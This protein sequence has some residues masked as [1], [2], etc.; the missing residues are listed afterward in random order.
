MV[1]LRKSIALLLL[2]LM[3]TLCEQAWGQ[4][5]RSGNV[6][7]TSKISTQQVYVGQPFL[8]TV[9]V[10]T[11]TWFASPVLLSE[12]RPRNSAVFRLSST[13]FTRRDGSTTLAG[14]TYTY[15]IFPQQ[16]GEITIPA[17]ALETTSPPDGDFK[18][19][20]VEMNSA[21]LFLTVLPPPEAYTGEQWLA[22]QGV[23]VNER[24]SASLEELKVGDA[25]E[26]SITVRAEGAVAAFIPPP[27]YAQ[28][29]GLGVYLGTPT[30]SDEQTRT[31]NTGTRIDRLT[32]VAERAGTYV[33]PEIHFTWWDPIR[34][35]MGEAVIEEQTFS[36]AEN[37]DLDPS[38]FVNQDTL[39]AADSLAVATSE[40]DIPWQN[41]LLVGG[42]ALLLLVLLRRFLRSRS[43][44]KAM[45]TRASKAESE[46][47]YFEQFRQAVQAGDQRSIKRQ[48]MFWLDRWHPVEGQAST[49]HAFVEEAEDATLAD[50]ADHL[51]VALYGTGQEGRAW[52]G[53]QFYQQVAKARKQ[54]T[55]EQE[56][57]QSVLPRLNP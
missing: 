2:V 45:A 11:T 33:L 42:A 49:V 57:Q 7:I 10:F 44:S 27:A 37:P 16:F 15:L 21:E 55:S 28:V 30:L 13:N 25:F 22:A 50:Q 36:V 1:T 39:A 4:T 26:R 12:P 9:D 46:A 53:R 35:R 34:E 40:R 41:M 52:S 54:G 14:I 23:A 29:E 19:R 8:V 48:F 32:Y 24:W 18:P 3:G 17:Q 20:D 38:L 56:A 51:D 43:R 47:N 6:S 31:N 5:T